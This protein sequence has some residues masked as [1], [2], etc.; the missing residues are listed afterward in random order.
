M[1]NVIALQTSE[2]PPRRRRLPATASKPSQS[3]LTLR[4]SCKNLSVMV[5]GRTIVIPCFVHNF[6]FKAKEQT[7]SAICPDRSAAARGGGD[8]DSAGAGHPFA[9]G[10][11][12]RRLLRARQ[13]A[14]L[15]GQRP[16]HRKVLRRAQRRKVR[17]KTIKKYFY[18]EIAK[19][20]AV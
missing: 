11:R 12:R 7:Y 5:S 4:R 20:L 18:R 19:A 1:T 16:G 9:G 6:L 8:R 14:P 15:A 17:L 2:S 3:A 13:G 10:R